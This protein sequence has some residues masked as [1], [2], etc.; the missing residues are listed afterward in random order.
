MA[1]TSHPLSIRHS[2]VINSRCVYLGVSTL[3]LYKTN[4]D[5]VLLWF[6]Q[7]LL[8]AFVAAIVVIGLIKAQYEGACS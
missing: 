4:R 8:P 7:A 3:G 6:I 2:S 5:I 1:D